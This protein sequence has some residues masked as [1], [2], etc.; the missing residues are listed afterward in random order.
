MK[1][2]SLATRARHIA[3]A[4]ALL[5]ITAF[6]STPAIAQGRDVQPAE[7]KMAMYDIVR[8]IEK[9]TRRDSKV[10][11]A[12]LRT[13]PEIWR[14]MPNKQDALTAAAFFRK[15]DDFAIPLE[16][17]RLRSALSNPAPRPPAVGSAAFF[18]NYPGEDANNLVLAA[19]GRVTFG[20][21]THR[22]NGVGWIAGAVPPP[23]DTLGWTA[24]KSAMVGAGIAMRIAQLG[25]TAVAGVPVVETSVCAAYSI[26]QLAVDVAMAPLNAANAWD[27]QIDSAELEAAYRNAVLALG[28]QSSHDDRMTGAHTA[29]TN[30]LSAQSSALASHNTALT[31]HDAWVRAKLG[32]M[33]GATTTLAD[34]LAVHDAWVRANLVKNNADMKKLLYDMLAKLVANQNEIIKLLKTPEA[35][36]PG[37]GTAGY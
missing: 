12:L 27:A 9:T 15:N 26:V 20:D 37:W 10:S 19:C 14:L 23:Y 32:D 24:Y 28:D 17:L 13:D 4:I 2:F 11:D 18:P 35:R 6:T 3:S 7:V 31:T 8:I 36:R 16:Q 25:C 34:D 1:L 29:Q 21:F 30:A 5:L 33:T 22:S